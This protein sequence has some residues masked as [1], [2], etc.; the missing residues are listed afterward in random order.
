MKKIGLTISLLICL[1][2]TIR[3]QE[4]PPQLLIR[5]AHCLSIKNFLPS[6]RATGLSFGYFL[7]E[8]SYP[9]E[10]VLYLVKF[11]GP[12]RLNGLIFAIFLT[13]RDGRQSFDIQNNARFVLSNAGSGSI[14]FVDPP[15]GGTW[16]QEH[17]MSAIKQIEKQP[18][19][20]LSAK[21]LLSAIPFISCGSYTDH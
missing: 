8:K 7:D 10:K 21:D 9:G 13:E 16:T 20:T 1:N 14:S 12:A 17:L 6:S 11:A 18:R 2:T 19:F 4:Q 3:A 15:L 5:A